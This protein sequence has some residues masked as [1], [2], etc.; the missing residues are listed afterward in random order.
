MQNLINA[1]GLPSIIFA[2]KNWRHVSKRMA[3]GLGYHNP[4]DFVFVMFK[5]VQF[6]VN[7]HGPIDRREGPERFILRVIQF[8]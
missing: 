6:W 5:V 1:V 2:P 7:D 4:D 8:E 3:R